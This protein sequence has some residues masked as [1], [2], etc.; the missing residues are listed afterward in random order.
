MGDHE[1]GGNDGEGLAAEALGQP[2][3][4]EHEERQHRQVEDEGVLVRVAPHRV[5]Q[6]DQ[7]R[8]QGRALVDGHVDVPV[9]VVV[10]LARD[11]EGGGLRG[12][13]VLGR[14]DQVRFVGE[15]AQGGMYRMPHDDRHG[16]RQDDA[17]PVLLHPGDDRLAAR[18]AR[19]VEVGSRPAQHRGQQ[20]VVRRVYAEPLGVAGLG[21]ADHEQGQERCRQQHESNV[22]EC[23]GW[24]VHGGSRMP[25]NW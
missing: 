19:S 23:P 22:A 8:K 5:N 12:K 20:E 6:A 3:G 11:R 7:E 25:Q 21:Q 2:V 14:S 9:A 13:E 10:V 24:L 15:H 17:R 1:Q 18:V 16:E 4:H